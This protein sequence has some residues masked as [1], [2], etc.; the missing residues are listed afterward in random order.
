MHVVED[1]QGHH[2]NDYSWPGTPRI[3]LKLTRGTLSVVSLARDNMYV[4]LKLARDIMLMGI[5]SQGH[6][7]YG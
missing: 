2:L 3:W 5:A 7:E 1:G 4:W 6:L